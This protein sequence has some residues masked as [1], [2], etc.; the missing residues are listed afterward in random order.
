MKSNEVE[1]AEDGGGDDELSSTSSKESCSTSMEKQQ[2]LQNTIK[3]LG[4]RRSSEKGNPKKGAKPCLLDE[5]YFLKHIAPKYGVVTPT[6]AKDAK[7]SGSG[8]AGGDDVMEN[9]RKCYNLI[10]KVDF[11]EMLRKG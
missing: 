10:G 8:G 4:D 5:Q 7:I 9:Y 1:C 11:K 6:V 3:Y 2:G